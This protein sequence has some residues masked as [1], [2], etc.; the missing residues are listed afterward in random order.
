MIITSDR[1]S[2][3]LRTQNQEDRKKVE[4]CVPCDQQHY[5][6][7]AWDGPNLRFTKAQ[8]PAPEVRT[9]YIRTPVEPTPA[10]PVILPPPPAAAK[11]PALDITGQSDDR[12]E[13]LR[14]ESLPVDELK[15]M[16]AERGVRWEPRASIPTMAKRIHAARPK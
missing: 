6:L 7:M 14:L 9:V 11:A 4:A 16:A 13:T 5:G 10:P 1:E 3:V 12:A 8:Q 15:T 2:I